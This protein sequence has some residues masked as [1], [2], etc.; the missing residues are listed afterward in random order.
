M[1]LSLSKEEKRVLQYCRDFHKEY[2]TLI[3]KSLPVGLEAKS[4]LSEYHKSISNSITSVLNKIEG[5]K[6]KKQSVSIE[7]FD[8]F[9]LNNP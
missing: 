7:S 8:E 6:T 5:K 9:D 2:S 4:E 1:K 3:E